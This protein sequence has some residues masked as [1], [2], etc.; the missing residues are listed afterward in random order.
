MVLGVQVL[1]VMGSGH[2]CGTVLLLCL[3]Q[4]NMTKWL[5]SFLTMSA[6][7]ST[8]SSCYK[9]GAALIYGNN[10]SSKVAEL[11]TSTCTEVPPAWQATWANISVGAKH[12]RSLQ[13]MLTR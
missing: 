3:C 13:Y 9:L 7:S 5:S 2:V 6:F 10:C 11:R 1:S 12:A 8:Q 4:D